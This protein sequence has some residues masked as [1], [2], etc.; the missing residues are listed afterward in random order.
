MRS[1]EEGKTKENQTYF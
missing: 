1:F